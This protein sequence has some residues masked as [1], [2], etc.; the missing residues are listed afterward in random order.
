MEAKVVDNLSAVDTKL[1][2]IAP[3]A[4]DILETIMEEKKTPL[5]LQR[6]CARD[7]LDLVRQSQREAAERKAEHQGGAHDLADIIRSAWLVAEEAR[8]KGQAEGRADLE[9]ILRENPQPADIEI[10][11]EAEAEYVDAS[12]GEDIEDD[13][14]VNE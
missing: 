11:V 2:L 7:I 13:V 8:E 14:A 4:V 6:L 5:A 12:S 10:E 9:R 3:K 1:R